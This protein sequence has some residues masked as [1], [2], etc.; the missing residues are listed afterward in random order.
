MPPSVDSPVSHIAW[1]IDFVLDR[2]SLEQQLAITEHFASVLKVR[3]DKLRDLARAQASPRRPGSGSFV[4]LE[5]PPSH[6]AGKR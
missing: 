1:F 2:Q 3:S 4:A 5:I 6:D